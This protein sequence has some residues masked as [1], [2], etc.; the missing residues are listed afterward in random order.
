MTV[1]DWNTLLQIGSVV[2]LGLTFAVGGTAFWTASRLAKQ[3]AERIAANELGTANAN[4]RAAKSEADAA[5]ANEGLAKSNEKI[6][7][8]TADAEK[9]KADKAESDKEIALAR[10]DAEKARAAAA[11]AERRTAEVLVEV[12]REATKRAEAEK[13]YIDAKREFLELQERVKPRHLEADE[14]AI[15][16][17]RLATS[18]I[19]GPVNIEPTFG[20]VEAIMFARELLDLLTE[21]GWKAEIHTPLKL[22]GGFLVGIAITAKSKENPIALALRKAMGIEILEKPGMSDDFVFLNVGA[23]RP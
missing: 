23:K 20:D 7:S 4:A 17:K 13:A 21:A 11:G 12:Q 8:L 14:R 16:L 9:F 22:G 10:A 3:Q 19:K 6:A 5:K 1:E 2:L 18:P 15:F